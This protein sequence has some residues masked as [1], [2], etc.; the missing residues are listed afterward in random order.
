MNDDRSDMKAGQ[1][2]D[3]FIIGTLRIKSLLLLHACDNS[4]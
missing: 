4:R 2:R 1:R 3:I